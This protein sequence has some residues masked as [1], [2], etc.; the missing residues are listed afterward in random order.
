[1][2]F[3]SIASQVDASY[4]SND[5]HANN[6]NTI[7]NQR[8]SL[9]ESASPEELKIMYLYALEVHCL[10]T[11]PVVDG[12]WRL[13]STNGR[14]IRLSRPS[15]ICFTQFIVCV[16]LICL[17]NTLCSAVMLLWANNNQLG[18]QNG[19]DSKWYH[20]FPHT[21]WF[22]TIVSVLCRRRGHLLI[23]SRSWQFNRRL[24]LGMTFNCLHRVIYL[25]NPGAND[26]CPLAVEALLSNNSFIRLA[27]GIPVTNTTHLDWKWRHQLNRK[28]R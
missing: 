5:L 18:L 4:H 25:Q 22:L 17:H 21:W 9:D 23:L 3:S 11:R 19:A 2:H 12:R 1:M 28:S 10:D 13:L 16:L 27:E 8:L 14:F 6:I 20:S 24:V 7:H 15:A 26:L